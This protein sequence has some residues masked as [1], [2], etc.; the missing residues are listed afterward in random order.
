MRYCAAAAL[1]VF[2]GAG[3]A[4]AQLQNRVNLDR[5]N[6]QLGGHV[7]DYTKNH[8]CDRRIFSPILGRPRD[9]YVYLPPCYSPARAYPLV[10]YLHMAAVDEHEFL[11][12]D[13]VRDLDRMIQ[14]GEF[15]PAVVV[16][17]DGLISGEN[18]VRNPHSL[19]INGRLGR[20]EDH[21]LQETLPFVT[22][23]YSIRPEREAHAIL[24]ASAGGFGGASIGLRHAETFGAIATLGAAL[25]LRY[26]TCN[27]NTLED[28]NPATFRWKT[29]YDP[30]EV[31]G[32][33][34]FGLDRV[35]ARKY[36]SPVFGDDVAS[37]P[38][39]IAAVNPADLLYTT[40]PQ[41]GRPFMYV[42]YA[43]RD[44]WNFDAEA[45]SFLWIAR[46]IGYPVDSY[47]DPGARHSLSYFHSN[48]VPAL[49]WLAKHLAPPA[50]N[51][52]VPA[53]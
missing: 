41:P 25:N 50:N 22:S 40:H 43:G 20:F 10:L 36:V 16:V 29:Q 39:R 27:D 32:K 17:P 30:D 15:P 53:E 19:F 42:N 12:V 11:G 38:A 9:L 28:F 44:N 47:R 31:V 14:A 2:L 8:G 46:Q 51:P 35:P 37:V 18:R 1:L 26:T 24:G 52:S 49:C 6:R 3:S 48:H 13:V 34:Y 5:L 45:E 21:L 4:H 23:H 33:F 7:V